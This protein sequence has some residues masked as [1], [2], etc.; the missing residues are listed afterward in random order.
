M[1]KKEHKHHNDHLTR[2]RLLAEKSDLEYTLRT[3]KER[4][5]EVEAKLKE[6]EGRQS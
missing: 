2:V 5:E 4:L 3:T 6:V 1:T